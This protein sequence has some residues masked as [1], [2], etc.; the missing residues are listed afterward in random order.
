MKTLRILKHTAV[1]LLTLLLVNSCETIESPEPMGD[2]GQTL[3]KLFPAGF[4]LIA[5]D[6]VATSQKAV[7][8]EVRKDVPSEAALNSSTTAVLKFDQAILDEYNEENEMHLEKL[9]AS[10]STITPA[11]AADGSITLTFAPGEFS[12]S[13]TITIPNAT[14]FDF[15]KQYGMAYKI[16]FKDGEGKLSESAEKEVIVQVLVKNK[17]DGV[18]EVTANSPMVDVLN[19]SLTG[20]YPFVYEL[21]TSGAHSVK[22]YDRD[23]W[24]DYMHPIYSG[25]SVSGYGAFG[26]EVFFDPSGN[27][28]IIDVKNPWGNP[29]A[30]TRMPAIDASGVNAWDPATKNVKFKYFMKQPSLVPDPPNIRVYFDET[31]T[32]KGAR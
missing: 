25:T 1:V 4:K 23:I 32:Y 16:E 11:P 31:W 18:Y 8:F 17:Y 19:A 12:K 6:A 28:K 3:V 29:P 21:Q 13:I 7:M 2:A 15:S 22:C 26:L 24:G 10:L 9:D 30:N 5:L 14:K 20:Y 27:G